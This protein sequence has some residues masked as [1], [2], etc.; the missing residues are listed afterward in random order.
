MLRKAAMPLTKV[1]VDVGKAVTIGSPS[2]S[3]YPA[4]FPCVPANMVAR[5]TEMKVKKAEA[6]PNFE[7]MLNVRGNEANHHMTVTTTAN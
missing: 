3:L 1:V 4:G 6:V 7:S 2:F 5:I